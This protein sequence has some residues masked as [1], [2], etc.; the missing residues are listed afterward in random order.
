MSNL[1]WLRA[2]KSWLVLS[3]C[4]WMAAG[5][6]PMLSQDGSGDLGGLKQRANAYLEAIKTGRFEEASQ[7]VVVDSRKAV[8]TQ[9]DKKNRIVSFQILEVEREEG[10]DSALVTISQKMF[11]PSM[12]MFG[13]VAV[14]KQQRWKLWEGKWY[15]N[16]S[17]PPQTYAA[18]VKEY[19]YDKLEARSKGDPTVPP[20]EVEFEQKIFDFGKVSQGTPVQSLF[21]YRNLSGSDIEVKKVH[22]PEWLIKDVT[23]QRLVAAGTDGEIRV[24]VNTSQL[25]T[26]VLQDFFVQFEPIQEMI[27][28]SIRGVVFKPRATTSS[29]KTPSL[30]TPE[31]AP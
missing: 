9:E 16:P 30:P 26:E 24:D 17:D 19:Y 22:A 18:L 20:L 23:T 28:L 31:S 8:A 27:K 7:Y 3:I 6:L 4:L 5:V 2:L 15:L 29:A 13:N 11:S 1:G 10:K 12:M 14:K 25:D 21:V